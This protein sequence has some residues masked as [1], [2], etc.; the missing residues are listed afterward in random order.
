[1]FSATAFVDMK[2]LREAGYATRKAARR[3]FFQK[4]R[5]LYDIDYESDRLTLVQALLLMTYW[6]EDPDHHKDARHWMGVAISLAQTL[7][8]HQNPNSTGIPAPKQGLWKRIWWS[9]FIRDRLIALG[10]RCP[11]R[12]QDNDCDV[13]M[14]VESDFDIQ[15]LPE[16]SSYIRVRAAAAQVS[17]MAM[18]LCGHQLDQYLP[19]TAITAILSAAVTH[20]LE[21]KS[22]TGWERS[23]ANGL[24]RKDL[25]IME[26]LGDIYFAANH[27]T[28]FLYAALRK[29]MFDIDDIVGRRRATKGP[30]PLEMFSTSDVALFPHDKSVA[31]Q[32]DG[33]KHSTVPN[34]IDDMGGTDVDMDAFELAFP[35]FCEDI[36]LNATTGTTLD[37]D[38]WLRFS[39]TL[40]N[41]QEQGTVCDYSRND[42][43]Q[44]SE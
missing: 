35:Q 1:M 28:E 40:D 29:M 39:P 2:H 24:F 26:A 11:T 33:G 36:D 8:L 30:P 18:D 43:S 37:L 5:T 19:A 13:P 16:D 41:S 23:R 44:E 9:C 14:L 34:S 25:C 21:M 31:S 7:G 10:M 4:T 27:A 32:T 15:V 3:I 38:D 42:L 12:I 22:S 20:L 6:Y 17:C